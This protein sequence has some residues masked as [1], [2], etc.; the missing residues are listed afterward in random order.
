MKKLYLKLKKNPNP[1]I[2]LLIFLSTLLVYTPILKTPALLLNRGNDLEEFFWPIIYFVKQQILENHQFPLWNNLFLSGMPLLPDPQSPLFYPPNLI[3]LF[4]PIDVAFIFLFIL[5]AAIGGIGMFILSKNLGLKLTT[6]LFAVILYIT[7]PKLFGYLEAGHVGLVTSFAWLPFVFIGT[8]KLI[9]SPNLKS[10]IILALPLAAIF[11]THIPTFLIAGVT[12]GLALITSLVLQKKKQTKKMFLLLFATALVFFGITAVTII[13]QL[14][15]FPYTTRQILFEKPE[16]F[17]QWNDTAEFIQSIFLPWVNIHQTDSEKWIPIGIAVSILSFY[18]FV[19]LGK[20]LKILILISAILL[21]ILNLTNLSP[22]YSLLLEQKWFVTLRVAT[23]TWFLASITTILLAAYGFELLAKKLHRNL[24][25]LV[26]FIA[27]AEFISLSY[28]RLYTPVVKIDKFA[29]PEVY[30]YLKNDPEKFRVF[31][32]NRC[33]SQKE[34]T[35]ANLELIDGYNTIQQINFYKQAWQLTGAYWNY[36]TLS[37]PPI[38]TY[39][40]EKPQP[41]PVS[42]GEFNTKYVISPY[43]L[44][45][46]SFILEK[47]FGD[48]LVYKN[49]AF[50]PRAYYQTDLQK[51][52]GEASIITY[53]PNRIRV[54]TSGHNTSRLVLS[55]VWSPGWKAYLNGKEAVKVQEKPNILRLVDIKPDTRFV[56]F[57]YEPDS[58][59][60]GRAIT[61][62]TLL[63]IAGY[64]A[65]EWKKTIK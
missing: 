43:K 33:L 60:I 31:C 13:P 38:G 44:E 28:S 54:D 35:L 17:P 48:Y 40:F 24:L 20:K 53:T 22:F 47:K 41:D 6:S 19:K 65:L 26:A 55:E 7:A 12:N 51:L 59:K 62:T 1:P 58:F 4:L 56:D 21:L 61:L 50:W 57:K 10:V 49:T 36:Y 29:A 5:H 32:V 11:Y 46:K 15:W 27:I 25:I 34:A 14:E 16:V 18:G 3:F 30:E 8:L 39:T 64:L 2:I 42:L 9:N 37:I 63:L 45:N 52:E 23:R